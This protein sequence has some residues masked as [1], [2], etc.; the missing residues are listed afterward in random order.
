M[1]NSKNV[2][3]INSIQAGLWIFLLTLLSSQGVWANENRIALVIGNGGYQS[4]PL[5]NPVYD[6]HLMASNLEKLG[7][8][9]IKK[10]H[11]YILTS[12]FVA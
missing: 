12:H 9:V 2:M 5:K 7:F 10:E 1:K 3:K 11:R 6:A 4:N 8:K